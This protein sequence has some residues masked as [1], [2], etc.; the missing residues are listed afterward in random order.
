MRD[1]DDDD[2]DADMAAYPPP[3]KKLAVEHSKQHQCS[4]CG[5]LFGSIGYLCQH[6]RECGGSSED[7]DADIDDVW[8]DVLREVTSSFNDQFQ[9]KIIEYN[10]EDKNMAY[11]RAF[12][13]LRPAYKERLKA[14]VA[15]IFKYAEGMEDSKPYIKFKTNYYYFRKEKKYNK[16]KALKG[17]LRLSDEFFDTLLDDY[18][19]EQDNISTSSGPSDSSSSEA[20]GNGE[21]ENSD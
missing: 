12:E 19:S 4:E 9:Q 3:P 8:F 5:A 18:M 7:S 16:A 14:F 15:G 11:S 17:A 21:I 2:D 10:S 1:H 20:S 6:M 13:E